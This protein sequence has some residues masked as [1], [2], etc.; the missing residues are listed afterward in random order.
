MNKDFLNNYK[1]FVEAVTSDDSNDFDSFIKRLHTLREER[2]DINIPLLLTSGIGLSDEGGEFG[3]IVKKVLFHGKPLS[4][5]NLDHLRSE[6]GDIIWYWI[7]ACRALNVDPYQVI[8]KNV[9]KLE[10]RYPSGSFD[11]WHSENRKE[12]DI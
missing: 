4:D 8:E 3:G 1:Q 2:D 11:I 12:G 7:N 9:D 6:L 5:E 10:A